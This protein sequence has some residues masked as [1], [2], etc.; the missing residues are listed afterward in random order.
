MTS[1]LPTINSPTKDIEHR[2]TETQSSQRIP[3]SHKKTIARVI[4]VSVLM[5][6]AV[7]AF[8]I[9]PNRLVIH[10]ES[11]AMEKWPRSVDG[12]RIAA[13]SDIHA[14]SPFVTESKL[15]Q[16]VAMTNQ[17][18]PDLIVLLGDYMVRNTWHSKEVEPEVI[19]KSLKGLQGPLG[20]YAVLGN[21][22]WWYN[23]E[24]VRTALETVGIKVIDND[25]VRMEK[26]GH[27]FWLV[28]LADAWTGRD[29]IAGTSGRIPA[30]EP[31]IAITHNPDILPRLPPN[32]LLTLGGHT[33]GGQVNLP[34]VGRLVVPSMYGQRYAAGHIFEDGKHLFV[35]T[36]IGMSVF[37]VRFRVPP[38]IA[39]LTL[40]ST[41]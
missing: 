25:V 3:A 29:D 20:V 15:Q 19:A 40:R 31:A 26:N 24:R 28:G 17:T 13:L 35:T 1:K 12:L 16:V 6:L 14:G 18:K 22:D 38:E 39:V 32:F 41:Q 7:W 2:D 4:V 34:F 8:L 27:P 30:G 10:E 21:H 11:L 36:G 33:H 9:E 37:P 5:F 23:G